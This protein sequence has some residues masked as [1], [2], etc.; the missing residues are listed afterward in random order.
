MQSTAVFLLVRLTAG[1]G[2]DRLIRRGLR[3]TL[4][5]A[6]LVAA[7]FFTRFTLFVA[8]RG[9]THCGLQVARFARVLAFI[10]CTVLAGGRALQGDHTGS[11]TETLP[12]VALG[13][14]GCHT[15]ALVVA[16]LAVWALAVVELA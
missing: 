15:L 3:D 12:L 11:V 7:Q 9:A 6:I 13:A 10:G 5:C 14:F 2:K 8:T 1:A 4:V 16:V